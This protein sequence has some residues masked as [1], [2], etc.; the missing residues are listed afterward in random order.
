MNSFLSRIRQVFLVVSVVLAVAVAQVTAIGSAY[1]Q[2]IITGSVSGSVVDST[3]AVIPNAAIT[4]T[5]LEKGTIFKTKSQGNGDFSFRILPIGIYKLTIASSGFSTDELARIAV[6]A[7]SDTSVGKQLMGIGATTSVVVEESPAAQLDTTQSQVTTT[8]SS[9]TLQSLPVMGNGFD[10]VALLEPGV[11]QTHDLMDSNSNGTVG[12]S[13][14]G[15]RGR[16][17]NFE[18]DGQSNND[19]SVAGPQ[20]FFGNQ[21]AIQEIQIIQ[22]NFSAQYGRNTG[23]VVNYITKS[24]T[25]KIHGSAFEF[26][27]GT[28]LSSLTNQDKS[29]LDG[30]CLPGQDPVA[31]GCV[32]ISLPRAD[33]NKWGATIGGPIIKGKLFAFGST[34]FEHTRV[35]QAP[36]SSGS[37]YTPTP[38][39]LAQLAA[40]FPNNP[41]V[42]ILQ[43]NGPYGVTLGNPQPIV[44]TLTTEP[45]TLP[46][47]GTDNIAI[48]AVQ[49]FVPTDSFDDQEDLGRLD[50][51]PTAKD[52]FFLRYLYQT[53][54]TYMI[55]DNGAAG[56]FYDVPGTTHSVGADWHHTFSPRWV[57]QIRYSFQESKIHF[58]AGSFPNCTVNSITSCPGNISFTSTSD[59]G[60]GEDPTLPQGR[61]VK[62]TQV[63]DNVNFTYGR[64]TITFGG[65]FDYQNSPNAFLPLYNGEGQFG[66][67]D[68]LIHQN[69]NF[70]LA[71]GNPVIPFTENDFALYFQDDWKLSSNLTVNLG[72]R[73]EFFGQAA[74]ELHRETLARESNPATAIWDTSLPVSARVFPSVSNAYK[75]FEPRIGFAWNPDFDKKLVVRGG[76]SIGFDPQFYNPFLNAA[77]VAPVATSGEFDCAGTCLSGANF[78]GAGLR[79]QN[80][81]SLPLGGNPALSDQSQFP[82]N[83]HNPY[84]QTYSLRLEH[85]VTDH[86]VVS[87]GYVGTHT[88]GEFQSVDANP[89]LSV[90]QSAFPSAAPVTLC[91]TP[92]APGIGR[93]NC[94]LG[95]LSYITNGAF[96]IYNGL[97]TE[98]T[99]QNLHG[100]TGNISYTWSHAIDNSSEIY[101]TGAGGATIALPQNPLDPNVAERGTSGTSYPNVVSVGA[102]YKIPRL[103]IASPWASRLTNGF[104]LNGIFQYNSGQP[105][106]PYQPLLG[107]DGLNPSYCDQTF[108]ESTVGPGA[109]T[110][111]LI[112]SNKHAP[113]N[114]AAILY[115]GT[116]YDLPSFL[117]AN[118]YGVGTPTVVSPASVRWI[119][120]NTDEANVLGNPYAG[121]GRNILRGQAFNELDLSLF[122]DTDLTK[123]AVLELQFDAFNVT[124]YQFR[125]TPGANALS[126]QPASMASVNPF[127]SNAYNGSG[128]NG[129]TYGNRYVQVGAKIKF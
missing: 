48:A 109:D 35:G 81:S 99:T 66:S 69:G 129:G 21:D 11:A 74:N 119:I 110:C 120:N 47:G 65:E 26:Y 18:L 105:Y 22:S 106:N 63:Q 111:R 59:L 3:G 12:F 8:F 13:S 100:F 27:T 76:Y 43:N 64:Q 78:S 41:V 5:D 84:M 60:F 7:N 15:S 118:F 44:S 6:N 61:T 77:T 73:W 9:E 122:K 54:P 82:S 124:N 58:Q 114:S 28:F 36:I 1:A 104:S 37:S 116:Y 33:D 57:N 96:T 17:N 103:T 52:S 91:S 14:N 30:F 98:I 53:D 34:Y 79:A 16:N 80:L 112:Q 117:G 56:T 4:A 42:A 19:N 62:V 29:A 68:S 126:A 31:T 108:D 40:D 23:T 83:F 25:N 95:N 93:P 128:P 97:Q 20:I 50:W 88:V 2:G 113:L 115:G 102:S 121:S 90:V 87:I 10:E 45:V 125:G 46:G 123:G 38:T 101:S 39:G 94:N 86:A 85:Q 55:S 127:L 70:L 71:A 92:G 72:L 24:G 107:L 67:L 89:D 49:R 51:Q 32:P 75:N